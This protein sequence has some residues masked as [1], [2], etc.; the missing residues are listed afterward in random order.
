MHPSV[1]IKVVEIILVTG[2]IVT[3]TSLSRPNSRDN[4][5]DNGSVRRKGFLA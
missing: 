3:K 1:L 4:G 2:S 5:R